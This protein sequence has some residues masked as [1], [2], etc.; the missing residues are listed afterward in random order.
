MVF[1]SIE[2]KSPMVVSQFSSVWLCHV[3]CYTVL[4]NA[5]VSKCCHVPFEPSQYTE[6]VGCSNLLDLILSKHSDLG[7]EKRFL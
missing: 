7:A 1:D 4:G 6:A 3:F 5:V 2:F